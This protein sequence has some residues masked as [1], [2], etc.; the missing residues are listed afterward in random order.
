MKKSRQTLWIL[1]MLAPVGA[2]AATVAKQTWIDG[3]STAIP[4]M[5]CTPNHYFRQCFSVTAA[6]CEETSASAARVCL[7]KHKDEIPG[8]LQQPQD[9]QRLGTVIGQCAG[10]AYEVTLIKKRSNN[11]KCSDPNNWK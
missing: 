8:V 3:M 7:N 6:E 11:P 9:G 10:S 1:M 2:G 5:F 4:T